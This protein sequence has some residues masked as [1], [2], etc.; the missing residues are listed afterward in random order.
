MSTP[1][2]SPSAF[3]VRN[4]TFGY[5]DT[6]ILSDVGFSV[7]SGDFLGIIGPNGS[8]KSTLLNL[9]SGTLKPRSGEIQ[10]NG[11]SLGSISRK[12][13]ARS[14]AVV[15]QE[16]T[17]TFG[18][19]AAQVVLMGRSPHL[20]RL[21]LEGKG[22]VDIARDAMTA[23]DTWPLRDR[24]LNEISGGEKQRVVIAR[25]LAQEARTLLLDEPTSALDIRHQVGIY[26]LL[27]RLHAQG[28][29]TIVLVSH[30][31]NLSAR[32]CTRLML[33]DKG[34]IVCYGPPEAVLREDIL[35][36]V[37]GTELHVRK[38]HHTGAPTVITPLEE[39][40]SQV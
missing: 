12:E 22:D 16:T 33:L 9:L 11:H 6:D 17:A 31:L 3:D 35:S 28:G 37:Y 2:T 40:V 14:V 23:T 18:F 34:R 36:R 26:N 38:D 19:T 39:M 10:L 24:R 30:D 7:K 15:P 4:L 25:A 8:G 20:G 21:S 13:I 5:G 1:D 29:R 32:A 27:R